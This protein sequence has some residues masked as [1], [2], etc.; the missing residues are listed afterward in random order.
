MANKTEIKLPTLPTD[1][2]YNVA[3]IKDIIRDQ[4]FTSNHY[5]K[6]HKNSSHETHY[7]DKLSKAVEFKDIFNPFIYD[8][9]ELASYEETLVCRFTQPETSYLRACFKDKIQNCF[10]VPKW[11]V[12]ENVYFEGTIPSQVGL[13]MNN[14]FYI[15]KPTGNTLFPPD[16]WIPLRHIT[17]T[18]LLFIL[19]PNQTFHLAFIGGFMNHF[20]SRNWVENIFKNEWFVIQNDGNC[21]YRAEP[22]NINM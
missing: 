22:C 12:F 7:M 8:V 3:K 21:V 18:T 6:R 1:L 10:T 20:K 14:N 4:K 17:K 5:N 11:D 9:I 15:I 16:F 2:R 13:Y 19:P